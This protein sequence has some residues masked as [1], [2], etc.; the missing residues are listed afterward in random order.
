MGIVLR[1]V[2]DTLV[3]RNDTT[4]D[5]V[6]GLAASWQVSPDGLTYT[7]V[8]RQD[9]K[10]HDG[11]PFNADAVKANLI[12]VL[13]PANHSQKAVQLL[14]PVRD[15]QVHDPYTLSISL[16]EPFAPLLDG[17]S[18]PY[19]GMASP[20][21]LSAYD[22]QTY[23]F[24]QVG[25][26]P[27][28]FVEY[29]VNDQ[30]VLEKNPDYVWGPTG[31]VSN[32]GVPAVNRVVFRFYQDV[33]SR[34]AA[35]ESGDVQ[36]MGELLPT[37]AQ[38]MTAD[39]KFQLMPVAVPGEPLQFIFN[40]NLVPTNSQA[41]RQALIQATDRQAIAQTV[42]HGYSPIAY[43]P[44]SSTTLYYDQN[45]QGLYSYNPAQAAA[46]FNSTGWVD[47][48][49]DGWRD[50][51]GTPIEMTL[52]IPPWGMIPDVAQLLQSQ[53]QT[54]LKIRVHIQQVASFPM[55]SD[56]AKEDKYNGIALNFF[57]LDPVVLNNF[58]QSTGTLNWSHV[59]DPDLDQLLASGQRE[60]DPAR[61]A[62]IYAEIQQ[63]IMDQALILP[64]REYVNLNAAQQGV[65]GLHFDAQ[66][67]FPYLTDLGLGQ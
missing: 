33:S 16:S 35:L 27:Y 56:A 62:E 54:N 25:T 4:H 49:S 10:F 14:G 48:D 47:S 53:W 9:V 40:T 1:S 36:I 58:Y 11:T 28:R 50:D 26:G 8:L 15:I 59:S 2:Y 45:V 19:L 44:L 32:T 65:A 42:F 30:I 37:D 66:G 46:L 13:D 39:K 31:I 5:F 41:A 60:V 43:G 24:H 52:V 38:R 67:W 17:L 12:R 34:A 51:K 7:F 20:V 22:A 3:Y 21:A 18:Q 23:Q 6:P 55:L 64:I 61:R 29:V 63:R 57:G